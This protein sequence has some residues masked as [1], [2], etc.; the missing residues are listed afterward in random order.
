VF[1]IAT[2]L[3]L[4]ELRRPE[5]RLRVDL[6]KETGDEE[7]REGPALPDPQAA[8]PEDAAAARELA[9]AL[10]R[11]IAALPGKQRAALLL[12]RLDGLAYRDVAE[13]LGCTEGAV[14]ALL[15]RAT[16]GL[17]GRL[18]DFIGEE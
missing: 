3:C 5:H 17:R 4:N 7:S 2:N 9:L 10:D 12:S 1:R 11:E 14:K 18:R 6:W 16:H 15:F 13:V 8:T